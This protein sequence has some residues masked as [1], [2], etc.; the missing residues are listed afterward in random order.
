MEYRI[1]PS[2]VAEVRATCGSLLEQHWC[3]VG[4]LRH[5]MRLS[6]DWARYEALEKAHHLLTLVARAEGSEEVIGY[7]VSF[8]TRHIHYSELLVAQNDVLFV[9]KAHRKS[10]LGYRLIRETEKRAQ[11]LGAGMML[12]HAKPNTALQSVLERG[13][14]SMQDL[15]YAKEL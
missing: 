10:R 4:R 12:W 14:Y 9:A 15:I 3:E 13:D 8:M 11:L 1:T 5:L 6:P 2:N 7:S